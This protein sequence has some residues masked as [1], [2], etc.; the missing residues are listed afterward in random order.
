MAF[1]TGFKVKVFQDPNALKTFVVSAVTTI[2]AIVSDNNGAYV[3][4][5]A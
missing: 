4:F 2:Y 5:Y 1:I 3:L